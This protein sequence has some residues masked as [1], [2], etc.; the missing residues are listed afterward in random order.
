MG[1]TLGEPITNKET[2]SC[3]NSY[4][5]VGSSSMQGW[6]I[7]EFNGIFLTF[8]KINL[9]ME[10]AHTHLL[11]LPDDKDAAFFAV[12]DGHGG[13]KV[14]HYASLHLHKKIV[15]NNLYGFNYIFFIINT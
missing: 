4:F 10:D 13:D 11:T 15:K 6:R 12:Y 2:A 7:S 8:L 1:Q 5:K 9:D 14:A 3:A